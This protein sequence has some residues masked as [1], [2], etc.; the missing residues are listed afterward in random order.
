MRRYARPVAQAV[1]RRGGALLVIETTEVSTGR[2]FYRLPGGTIE[3]GERG[4]DSV[5]REI[6]EEFGVSG[7]VRGFCGVIENI[8]TYN[9]E[10]GH[11]LILVFDVQVNDPEWSKAEVIAGE[12]D[13]GTAFT[14]RWVT[15]E[16]ARQ[17]GRPVYPD[18][19]EA[20]LAERE[21]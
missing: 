15:F 1:L 11:E 12:E 19:L 8:Y 14:C 5:V 4:K 2:Q 10:I 17:E 21:R 16:Q 3:F 20:L 18:G 7:V 6:Q 13:D 9:G